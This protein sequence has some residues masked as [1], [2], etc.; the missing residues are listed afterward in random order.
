MSSATT[1]HSA[2]RRT[3]V[4]VLLAAVALACIF[5]ADAQAVY[6]PRLGRFLQRDP[7][8]YE[9]GMGLYE[10]VASDPT[11]GRDPTGQ[12]M[13][14]GSNLNDPG[15]TYDGRWPKPKVRLTVKPVTT[16]GSIEV[17]RSKRQV[18]NTDAGSL[19]ALGMAFNRTREGVNATIEFSEFTSNTTFGAELRV[20]V[21]ADRP[22]T[23]QIC[24]AYTWNLKV[25]NLCCM[26]EQVRVQ[27]VSMAD[28][29]A[30]AVVPAEGVFPLPF[31]GAPL[32]LSPDT[33]VNIIQIFTTRKGGLRSKFKSS[34]S[35]VVAVECV[36]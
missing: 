30:T 11:V 15:R 25:E 13:I 36:E 32:T 26:S 6:H 21:S 24:P 33:K 5:T 16:G 1:S 28:P 10:Y 2:F 19:L 29:S 12:A 4:A 23:W 3:T 14:E 7:I 17:G 35:V 18:A 20:S 31:G 27:T 9:D 8:G 34:A 22:R